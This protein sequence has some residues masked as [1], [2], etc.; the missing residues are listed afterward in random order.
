MMRIS[1]GDRIYLLNLKLFEQETWPSNRYD[2]EH[3]MMM[4]LMMVMKIMIMK[5]CNETIKNSA[6]H[7]LKNSRLYFTVIFSKS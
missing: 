7:L 6:H 2:H 4:G 3:L 5:L 1:T